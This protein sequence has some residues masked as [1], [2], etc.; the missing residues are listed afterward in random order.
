MVLP[1]GLFSR[2]KKPTDS[3]LADIPPEAAA[4]VKLGEG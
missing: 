3:E 2:R 4:I 1:V